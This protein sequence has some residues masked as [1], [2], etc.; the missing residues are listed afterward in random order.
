MY[1]LPY[2]ILKSHLID[3]N[4][5]KLIIEGVEVFFEK[6]PGSKIITVYAHVH[7]DID[8]LNEM[9]NETLNSLTYIKIKNGVGEL[10]AFPE[11]GFVSIVS[12]FSSIDTFIGFKDNMKAFME[13]FDFWKSV[14]DDVVK[15]EGSLVY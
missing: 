4:K 15:T 6:R 12:S 10:K 9:L 2:M 1:Y 3:Q 14:V 7:F 13:L 11:E 8:A 5:A